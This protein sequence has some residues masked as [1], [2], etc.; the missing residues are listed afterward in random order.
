MKLISRLQ[1]LSARALMQ[2]CFK[3]NSAF[4]VG[5]LTLSAAA[6]GATTVSVPKSPSNLF[7]FEGRAFDLASRALIYTEHHTI[8]LDQAGNYLSQ[9]VEYKSPEG[10]LLV[11]KI[12][13]YGDRA[14]LPSMNFQDKRNNQ[15][16]AA[17]PAKQ[18]VYLE[19]GSDAA[20]E[21]FEVKIASNI[22]PVL[23]A[24]FDRLLS[25]NWEI[26]RSGE[27]LE[28]DFFAPTRAS[29]IG[30]QLSEM[31][32]ATPDIARFKIEPSTWIVRLLVEPI[33]LDYD[34]VS[35]RLLRYEGIT[36]IPR[37]EG[38]VVLDENYN[39][40]ILYSY[41]SAAEPAQKTS[42]K[43]DSESRSETRQSDQAEPLVHSSVV[44]GL[45]SVMVRPV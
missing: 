14:F 17:T 23:D 37:S 43:S 5:L 39:A 30:F 6:W 19:R 26:L 29:M 4:M 41:P 3:V 32:S 27:M 15:R 44:H 33:I 25:K 20:L 9:R 13:E 36:N 18:H 12:L 7:E 42:K 34:A 22:T 2:T 40:E 11:M 8:Q 31:P 10:E 24:G 21:R 28:F 45:I 38:G 16:I 1:H 35:R